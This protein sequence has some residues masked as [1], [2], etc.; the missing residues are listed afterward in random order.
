MAKRAKRPRIKSPILSL[1]FGEMREHLGVYLIVTMVIGLSVTSYTVTNAYSGYMMQ[2]IQDGLQGTI[3]GDALIMGPGETPRSA[4]GGAN[5]FSGYSDIENALVSEGF[6]VAPRVILQG[7]AFYK[8][9]ESIT[10][11]EINK[12]MESQYEGLVLI[13][14]DLEK[15]LQVFNI[16]KNLVGGSWFD[17]DEVENISRAF[18]GEDGILYK[19]EYKGL[20]DIRPEFSLP[21]IK[22][23][24]MTVSSAFNRRDA[25]YRY[26]F[27]PDFV[28]G[29]YGDPES[30]RAGLDLI[31]I[32]EDQENAGNLTE[33][34]S[35]ETLLSRVGDGTISAEA[36]KALLTFETLLDKLDDKER[37]KDLIPEKEFSFESDRLLGRIGTQE[38]FEI[39]NE[40]ILR[41]EFIKIYPKLTIKEL[42]DLLPRD[43]IVK[44]VEGEPV[45]P[46]EFKDAVNHTV[47]KKLSSASLKKMIPGDKLLSLI[48]L[49]LGYVYSIIPA[50]GIKE[51]LRD[52]LS[53]LSVK[54]KGALETEDK[55]KNASL[56]VLREAFVAE[57]L[58][59]FDN[60]TIVGYIGKDDFRK[61]L[62]DEFNPGAG[63]PT[64]EWFQERTELLEKVR[65]DL[66]ARFAQ[67]E[68]QLE[69]ASEGEESEVE[70]LM[71]WSTQLREGLA[72]GYLR[73]ASPHL[74]LAEAL[75]EFGGIED[76]AIPVIVGKALAD[77]LNLSIGE[78]FNSQM[79]T[80][81]T[82][83]STGGSSNCRVV[84]LYEIGIP[85]LEQMVQI[86]PLSIIRMILTAD[87][88]YLVEDEGWSEDVVVSIGVSTPYGPDEKPEKIKSAVYNALPEEYRDNL[89]IMVYTDI[90]EYVVGPLMTVV[91]I[92]L[93]LSI[94]VTLLLCAMTIKY[95]MDS[96]VLRKTREIGTLKAVG[97]T[98]TNVASIFLIQAVIIG[99]LASL[100][101]FGGSAGILYGLN[102]MLGGG[103]IVGASIDVWFVLT[104]RWW[105]LAMIFVMPV[106]VALISALIPA[107]RAARLSPV[108]SIRKGEMAL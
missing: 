3:T 77:N 108:E 90:I 25:D 35:E 14:V 75:E 27:T 55:I 20:G 37:I 58:T 92:M 95:V 56:E 31:A 38:I 66:D 65:R 44:L 50:S 22:M 88:K 72:E 83:G 51:A 18:F 78:K 9:P 24:F 47:L 60:E 12:L 85:I 82:L 26:L 103:T 21:A 93:L 84:G 99:I 80:G 73:T 68:A 34:F 40:T 15:D 67:L 69:G 6:M 74:P 39:V 102:N 96:T 86:A 100:I 89:T 13:G 71:K 28:V 16:R 23:R 43:I 54:L 42:E 98:S 106:A 1:A 19:W 70:Q 64:P 8:V 11:M 59:R 49:D 104:W 33:I 46:G 45:E 62:Y 101:G 4:L 94:F 91:N 97:A 61:K 17:Q 5:P 52:N 87:G 41:D 29:F 79:M 36:L 48:E 53:E 107:Y 63:S 105:V 7:A 30:L 57:C 10:G 2:T 76:F 81:S 32:R